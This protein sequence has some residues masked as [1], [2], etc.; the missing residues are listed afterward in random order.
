ML[1][2]FYVVNEGI[3]NSIF[4]EK[5]KIRVFTLKKKRTKTVNL[6]CN[7]FHVSNIVRAGIFF[8]CHD[9][10]TME[11]SKIKITFITN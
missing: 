10:D 2:E 11:K 7:F 3:K 5:E 8:M 4:F 9:C 6:L 1:L